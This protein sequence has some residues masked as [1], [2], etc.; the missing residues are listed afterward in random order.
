M[1]KCCCN[2]LEEVYF[3]TVTCPACRERGFILKI[4]KEKETVIDKLE[5]KILELEGGKE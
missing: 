2:H 3:E 4:I 5:S 1:I